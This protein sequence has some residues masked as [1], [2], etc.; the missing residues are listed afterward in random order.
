MGPR[1]VASPAPPPI[2]GVV[3]KA[4]ARPVVEASPMPLQNLPSEPAPEA[5]PGSEPA[6]EQAGPADGQV[7]PANNGENGGGEDRPICAVCQDVM[8]NDQMALLCG[9]VYH[10]VCLRRWWQ[11]ARVPDNTCPVRCPE[12]LGIIGN[13]PGMEAANGPA[14]AEGR[15]EGEQAP[16]GE[17]PAAVLAGD[18]D[19]FQIV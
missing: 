11:I 4:A 16:V 7:Q 12:A 17:E 8:I 10:G 19:E 3:P 5:A 18:G 2:A 1:P 15:P 6:P 14:E 9:H 13:N